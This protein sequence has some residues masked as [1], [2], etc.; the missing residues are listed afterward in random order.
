MSYS[1]TPT[2]RWKGAE[3]TAKTST[4][5]ESTSKPRRAQL[6]TA[7]HSSTELSTAKPNKQTDKQTDNIS[8]SA[9]ALSGADAL[10]ESDKSSGRQPD[11]LFQVFCAQFQIAHNGESYAYKQ[12]DFIKLAAM[13]ERYANAKPDPW[14]VTPERFKQAAMHYFESE[15]ATHT[16]ADLCERFSTFFRSALDRFNKPVSNGNGGALNGKGKAD[17]NQRGSQRTT[18]E[19]GIRDARQ[20]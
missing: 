4:A 9:I 2:K 15:L 13:R 10:D 11:P 12:A 17:T 18:E 8:E 14:E 19:Y 16:L 20:I 7:K 5:K 1:L 6:S 3:S